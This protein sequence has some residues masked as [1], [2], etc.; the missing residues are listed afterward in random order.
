LTHDL[1]T[2]GTGDDIYFWSFSSL[3]G[4]VT[5]PS[6]CGFYHYI[7][8]DRPAGPMDT[9]VDVLSI[10]FFNFNADSQAQILLPAS[11][12]PV[13]IGRLQ[14]TMPAFDGDF[15]LNLI[16]AGDPDPIRGAR[17]DFGF[18]PH[19]IWEAR[20]AAPNDVT[21]G[22]VLF[23]VVSPLAASPPLIVPEP[24]IQKT[25][26]LS[27]NV[28]PADGAIGSARAIKITMV[29]LQNPNP[30]NLPQFPPPNFGT[31]ES[32]TC[33]AAGEAAGCARWVGKPGTFL[34]SQDSP[35]LGSFAGALLQCTPYYHDFAGEGLL[36]VTGAE[37]VPSSTYEFEVFES[38]CKGNESTC[39]AV[40]APVTIGTHRSGDVAASY[41]APSPA[42][43]SQPNVIDVAQLV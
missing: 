24:D 26:V 6:F 32:E 7:D 28:P 21:G 40:S 3:N 1:G 4:C 42:T 11:G 13:T 35:G 19:I 9:R 39:T 12:A 2:P 17:M 20:L 18:D 23:H 33:T 34:E 14:V 22:T 38:I 37:I 41:Q 8:G 10:V 29:D 5:N 15:M 25:R 27:F 16:N 36:H 43:L 31:Y 30:P